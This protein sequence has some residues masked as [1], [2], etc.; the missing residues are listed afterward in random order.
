MFFHPAWLELTSEPTALGLSTIWIETLEGV[1]I[2]RTC[3]S[4]EL[5]H[6]IRSQNI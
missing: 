6:A 5:S 1:K 2:I 3:Q 4:R